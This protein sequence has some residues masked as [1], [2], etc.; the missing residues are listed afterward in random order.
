MAKI[1]RAVLEGGLFAFAMPR[2]SGK[3]TLARA[4]GLWAVLYGHR[5]YVCLIGSAEDQAKAMLDAIKREM[6][7]NALLLADFPEAIHPIVK[8][9]NNARRQIDQLCDGEPT[10]YQLGVRPIGDAHHPR[11]ARFRWIITVAGLDS[12]IRGQQHTKMDGTIIR[13]SLVILDDPQTRQSAASLTQTKHRLSI[14]NGGR[15]RA[16][17]SRGEDGRV[18]EVHEDLPR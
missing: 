8:L 4:A 11:L 3:T 14:R 2:G 17:R 7:A 12:N 10:L 5:E 13:P 6:L 18:H 16:R 9:E 1:E 15:P